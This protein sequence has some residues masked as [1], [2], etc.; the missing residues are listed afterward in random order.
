MSVKQQQKRDEFLGNRYEIEI[1]VSKSPF[2]SVVLFCQQ[3]PTEFYLNPND[4]YQDW[5]G[6][7][8]V[9]LLK[10]PYKTAYKKASE[11]PRLPR[12][13]LSNKLAADPFQ[14]SELLASTVSM[15]EML[16]AGVPVT[17][18]AARAGRL[19]A[20][21]N[22]YEVT[23]PSQSLLQRYRRN[24]TIVTVGQEFY[25]A[26]KVVVVTQE[27][28]DDRK[29]NTSIK[30]PMPMAGYFWEDADGTP[31]QAALFNP[32]TRL[33]PKLGVTNKVS[34]INARLYIDNIDGMLMK[35]DMPTLLEMATP[36]LNPENYVGPPYRRL[37]APSI[38][39]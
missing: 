18:I 21:S 30:V 37:V 22:Y 38:E 24:L 20:N 29:A 28:F 5:L 15:H 7:K 33:S 4:I 27:N 26:N 39:A 35:L 25:D 36:E 31:H 3:W 13:L 34:G 17:I 8:K 14:L 9:C 10:P 1:A 23:P 6:N 12:N 19:Q 32:P 11:D 2:A 16:H